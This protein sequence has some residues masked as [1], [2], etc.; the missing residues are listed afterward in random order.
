MLSTAFWI[1]GYKNICLLIEELAQ[2]S[3]VD[4]CA[5]NNTTSRLLL[6]IIWDRLHEPAKA[7]EATIY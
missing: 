6:Q 1:F 4:T 7:L 3:V 5:N 2:W